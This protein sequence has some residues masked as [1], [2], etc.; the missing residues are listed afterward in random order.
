MRTPLN[1]LLSFAVAAIA[2]A[3]SP[4][5]QAKDA[6][7]EAQTPVTEIP[8]PAPIVRALYEPYLAEGGTAPALEDAA[9]WSAAM[10]AA[11]AARTPQALPFDPLVDARDRYVTSVAAVT[12]AVVPNSHASVR[13]IF[14]NAGQQREIV[15]DLV[16]EDGAWRV[17]NIR[18]PN[19]GLRQL[20]VR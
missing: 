3:C 2:L 4:P 12:D 16:W 9:P 1:I 5:Q 10:R 20:L 19:W 14:L 18:S 11:L 15:Y 13:A 8:D 17:D 7:R 6:P